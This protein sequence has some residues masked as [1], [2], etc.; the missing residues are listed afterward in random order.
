MVVD[1]TLEDSS[2]AYQ[3]AAKAYGDPFAVDDIKDVVIDCYNPAALPC[4]VTASCDHMEGGSTNT[5]HA[6]PTAAYQEA[7]ATV[8]FNPSLTKSAY[9]NVAA[10]VNAAANAA[11]LL[12][13][14][15]TTGGTETAGPMVWATSRYRFEDRERGCC[16]PG[17]TTL[18]VSPMERSEEAS[19]GET[20]LANLQCTAFAW[21]TTGGDRFLC[22]H[23]SGIV[24][25]A[26]VAC[27]TTYC[28]W[29]K[30]DF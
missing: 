9:D 20:C 10:E 24:K 7:V 14:V 18:S 19:C 1:I 6:T 25:A 21:E 4:V 12:V 11:R 17:V 13:A 2:N 26:L 28:T 23:H 15:S 3:E 22:H 30:V 16:S 29:N 27:R 8:I 5:D